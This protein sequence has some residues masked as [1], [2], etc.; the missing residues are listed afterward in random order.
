[1]WI[2]NPEA[3]FCYQIDKESSLPSRFSHGAGQDASSSR[4]PFTLA[5][6]GLTCR[7]VFF[8]VYQQVR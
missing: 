4:K 8:W 1:L 5:G 6:F 3:G 7:F 2:L